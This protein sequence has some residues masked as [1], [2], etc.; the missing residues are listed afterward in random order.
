MIRSLLSLTGRVAVGI[1]LTYE[2]RAHAAYGARMASRDLASPAAPF[3]RSI[4]GPPCPHDL[5]VGSAA[6]VTSRGI[7]LS[8]GE[9]QG[10]RAQCR[11]TEEFV[12]GTAAWPGWE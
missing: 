9:G 11:L 1:D 10:E 12:V 4:A 7:T 2:T 6:P 8:D 3:A 5:Q